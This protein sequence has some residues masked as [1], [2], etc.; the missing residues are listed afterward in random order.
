M[1]GV[2]YT[3]FMV[4]SLNHNELEDLENDTHKQASFTNADNEVLDISGSLEFFNKIGYLSADE[5]YNIDVSML[6]N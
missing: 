3:L 2:Y 6:L 4:C 5:I 1:E